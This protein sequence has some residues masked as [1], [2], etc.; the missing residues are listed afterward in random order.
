[1]NRVR[2][3]IVGAGFSGLGMAIGLK[4]AGIEFALFERGDSLG[5]TWRDNSY[6]GCKCDV[7]SHLYSLSFAPNPDWRH[8]YSP[9]AEIWEYLERTAERFGILPHVR[10][11]CELL[12][13]SW[14]EDEHCWL[15][16][17]SGG[18]YRADVL[19]GAC[20]ALSEPSIPDFPGL[21]SFQGH[22]FHS[23][24]WDH[25]HDLTG[26]RVAV[27]GIGASAVQF[28]PQIQ[29]QVKQLYLFQRTP[30]WIFP[31]PDR[32][33]SDFERA[34]YRKLPILQ[35]LVRAGIYW[36]RELVA[37]ALTKRPQAT[38]WLARMSQKHLARQV[39]DPELRRKLTPEYSPG[40]K[41]ML[42]SNDF[43]PAI[44]APNAELVVE[45]IREIR[46]HAIVTSDGREREIDTLVFGTGFH[47]TDHPIASRIFG[48]GGASL[49]QTWRESGAQAYL[50]TTVPGFPNFFMM[51]GPN[52]G[53]GHTS[54]VVMIEAQIPYI[55]GCLRQM[56]SQ[57]S[58]RCEVRR[59]A[60]EAYNEELQRKMRRTVWMV[61]GCSSWYLDRHR[62]NTTLWPDFTWKYRVR[63]RRF[64]AENYTFA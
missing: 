14:R 28:I 61:G 2:V 6:P 36:S 38:R 19:I 35:C 10:F 56:Q 52:T 50:G 21:A 11:G 29:P 5:G 20:G 63:M 58:T 12:R 7:P 4:R 16:E 27:I 48:A 46:P 31:H 47:V 23:A 39:A 33:I 18:N 43:Y 45:P 8:T 54:L 53:I 22:A 60:C 57:G 42:I 17:T 30:A 15:L 55:L 24:R 40:C 26:E 25:A 13:A 51:T 44:A 1:M 62:R 49:V 41:R 32:P 37:F 9:Q 3:A 34:L 59:E 64:D